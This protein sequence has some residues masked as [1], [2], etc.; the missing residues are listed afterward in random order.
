MRLE[1]RSKGVLILPKSKLE[2]HL[3]ILTL[4]A[5]GKPSSPTHIKNKT[6]IHHNTL[7]RCLEF[8]IQQNLVEERILSRD[9]V[10]YAI[11]KRGVKV[12][13]VVVPIV[14]EARKIPAL[15]Y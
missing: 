2:K 6:G 5:I 1:N 11:T 12:L 15:L 8:L 4:L 9:R 14:K 13:N 7:K 10:S 3:E